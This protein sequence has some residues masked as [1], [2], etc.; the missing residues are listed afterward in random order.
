MS[1]SKK[2]KKEEQGEYANVK[3]ALLGNDPGKQVKVAVVE[4]ELVQSDMA[5]T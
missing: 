5:M 3:K 2:D 1:D 4:S